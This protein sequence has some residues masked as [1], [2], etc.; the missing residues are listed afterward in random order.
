MEEFNNREIATI[1]WF[2]ALLA[3]ILIKKR[4]RESV[5]KLLVAFFNIKIV[6]PLAAYMIYVSFVLIFL[7]HINYWDADLLKATIYWFIFAGVVILWKSTRNPVPIN[8]WREKISE[9]F[10]IVVILTFIINFYT[11]TLAIEM[12]LIPFL[13]LIIIAGSVAELNSNYASSEK[14]IKNIQAITGWTILIIAVFKTVQEIQNIDPVITIKQLLLPLVM[15]LAVIPFLY[16]I[17]I[18]IIYDRLWSLTRFKQSP[19]ITRYMRKKIVQYGKLRLSRM[20]ILSEIKTYEFMNIRTMKE[21][22]DLLYRYSQI[23]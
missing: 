19:E 23:H 18:Y 12:I 6:I 1:F 7:H 22:D 14:V 8:Y 11:F 4:I 2:T 15:T 16:L 13:L 3:S 17:S 9:H 5:I 20:R 10:S 21:F